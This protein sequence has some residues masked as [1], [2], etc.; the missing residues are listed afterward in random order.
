MGS[1]SYSQ[2]LFSFEGRISRSAYWLKWMLPYWVIIIAFTVILGMLSD[3]AAMSSAAKPMAYEPS[4]AAN[5]ISIVYGLFLLASIWPSLAVGIKRWHDRDK[6]GWWMLIMFV[7]L[8]GGLW[9]LIETGF[10]K[11]TTGPNR[12]GPDPVPAGGYQPAMSTQA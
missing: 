2:F 8:I 11:G 4:P 3:G 5:A 6:S 9:Y 12:F 1:M 7:P 10:L